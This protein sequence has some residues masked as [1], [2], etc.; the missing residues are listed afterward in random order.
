MNRKFR[1]SS[2]PFFK[3]ATSKYF[4]SFLRRPKLR[5]KPKNEGLLRKKNTKGLILKQKGTKM[6]EDGED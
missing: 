6:A 4:K 3:G 1:V 5:L 2:K